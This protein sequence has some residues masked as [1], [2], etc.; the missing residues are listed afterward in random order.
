MKHKLGYLIF[1]LLF[2]SPLYLWYYTYRENKVKID[3]HIQ[4]GNAYF[5]SGNYERAR[6]E[7]YKAVKIDQEIEDLFS[8]EGYEK[9][10]FKDYHGAISAFTKSIECIKSNSPFDYLQRGIC[11]YLTGDSIKA[12]ADFMEAKIL[13]DD[14]AAG[15]LKQHCE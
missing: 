6:E 5:D 13:G 8:K 7:Y 4:N 3:N 9:L 10:S 2:I 11:F 12:C 1:I 14:E 15:Y